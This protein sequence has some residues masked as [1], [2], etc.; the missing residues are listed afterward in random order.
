MDVKSYS[1]WYDYSRARDAMFAVSDT[2]DSPWFVVDGNDKRR[3]TVEPHHA[4]V[5]PDPL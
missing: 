3:R 5:E 4:L 1:H 2:D